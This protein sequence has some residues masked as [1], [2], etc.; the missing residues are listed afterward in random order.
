M[1][2][3]ATPQRSGAAMSIAMF[4]HILDDRAV[5]PSLQHP[6]HV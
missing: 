5:S 1:N 3:E 2:H 4:V 6:V